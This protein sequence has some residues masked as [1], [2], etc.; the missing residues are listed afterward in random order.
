MTKTECTFTSG[1]DWF[2]LRACGIL[3]D[4]GRVLMVRNDADPYYYSVGGGVKHGEALEAAAM[5]EVREETGWEFAIDRLVFIHE[6]FFRGKGENFDGLN[7]HELAFYF[8]MKWD[9]GCVIT[10]TSITSLGL[11]EHLEWLKISQLDKLEIPVYPSFFADELPNFH[12][13]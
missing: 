9:S 1:A 5:R 13:K 8:L 4:E 2:R 3:I 11:P 10:S 6:N 7:C 12:H